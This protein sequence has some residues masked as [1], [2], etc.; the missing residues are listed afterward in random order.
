MLK[1]V[2][3][4]SS[5]SV[6]ELGKAKD[7]Y[8]GTLGLHVTEDKEMQILNL[9]LKGGKVMVYPKDDHKAATFT[10]LN[11][12]VGEIDEVVDELSKKG[13]EFE[14]YDEPY[15]KTDEKG[16]SRMEGGP[17]MAWFKDPAGNILG[18]LQE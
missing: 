7:F 17:S 18:I 9:D 12:V 16:I 5:F 1:D 11:F 15:V 8:G 6:D 10:V 14:K 13:V 4:F 2:P 3:T